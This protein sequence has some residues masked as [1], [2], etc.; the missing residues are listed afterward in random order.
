MAGKQNEFI[1]VCNTVIDRYNFLVE[2]VDKTLEH[3]EKC[4]D[5]LE[6]VQLIGMRP[7]TDISRICLN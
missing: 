5:M 7:H 6:M 4:N 3:W 2:E 1:E